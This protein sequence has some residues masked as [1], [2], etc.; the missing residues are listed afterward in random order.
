MGVHVLKA[1]EPSCP[2]FGIG[3]GVFDLSSLTRAENAANGRSSVR[4]GRNRMFVH[5]LGL[6]WRIAVVCHVVEKTVPAE[7]D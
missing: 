5:V 3:L 7:S 4:F 6:F 1:R 2:E